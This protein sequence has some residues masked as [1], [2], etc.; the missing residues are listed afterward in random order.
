MSRWEIVST[1]EL[2]NFDSL[3]VSGAAGKA[4]PNK[5]NPHRYSANFRT[6]QYKLSTQSLT[7]LGNLPSAETPQATCSGELIPHSPQ[8]GAA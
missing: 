7:F 2:L 4:T 3:K 6:V 5:L 1:P 8:W